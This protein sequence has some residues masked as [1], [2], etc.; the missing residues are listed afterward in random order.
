MLY[1]TLLSSRCSLLNKAGYV[2]AD[3]TMVQ[4]IL[5]NEYQ[6]SIIDRHITKLV[7]T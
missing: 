3:P 6:L 1:D 2:L 5:D 7:S 4:D